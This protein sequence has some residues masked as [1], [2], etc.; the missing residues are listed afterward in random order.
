VYNHT[1]GEH[2]TE[3]LAIGTGVTTSLDSGLAEP[4]MTLS[5]N[6]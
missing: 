6:H 5:L 4:S 3:F 1:W 2:A